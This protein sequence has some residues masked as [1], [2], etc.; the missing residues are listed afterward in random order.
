MFTIF[1]LKKLKHKKRQSLA[2]LKLNDVSL[3]VGTQFDTPL[4]NSNLWPVFFEKNFASNKSMFKIEKNDSI[5]QY[6]LLYNL[7]NFFLLKKEFQDFGCRLVE[8][9]SRVP[10]QGS[11]NQSNSLV[12]STNCPRCYYTSIQMFVA[13]IFRSMDS[14]FDNK[15]NEVD[16]CKGIRKLLVNNFYYEQEILEN[17]LSNDQSNYLIIPRN[18]SKLKKTKN[19][20]SV[21]DNLLKKLFANFDLNKDKFVDYG[22]FNFVMFKN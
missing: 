2:N 8:T 3:P 19:K 18:A 11:S 22:K 1:N 5:D 12:L 9:Y 14:D 17:E 20:I 16:F 6:D 15:L 7:Q 13:Q 21:D 10:K 4:W